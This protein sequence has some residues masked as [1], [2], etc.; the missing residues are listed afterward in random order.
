MKSLKELSRIQIHEFS[1]KS[2]PNFT[3]SKWIE[4]LNSLPKEILEELYED[5]LPPSSEYNIDRTGLTAEA[6]LESLFL[7]HFCNIFALLKL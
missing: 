3:N 6:Y 4:F 5:T 2:F 1:L 7:Q